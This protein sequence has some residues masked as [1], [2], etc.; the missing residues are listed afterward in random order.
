MSAA[1]ASVLC[2]CTNA[3][4]AFATQGVSTTNSWGFENPTAT[5]INMYQPL[6]LQTPAPSTSWSQVVSFVNGDTELGT[7]TLNVA[8]EE[9]NPQGVTSA[10]VVWRV[11]AGETASYPFIGDSCETQPS[12][13]QCF[14]TVKIPRGKEE[15]LR[16]Q[17]NFHAANGNYWW[18]AAITPAAGVQQNVGLIEV[19]DSTATISASANVVNHT[20]YI[21]TP[22]SCEETPQS[23]IEWLNPKSVAPGEE[24]WSE[25]IGTPSIAAGTCEAEFE[26]LTFGESPLTGIR[27]TAPKTHKRHPTL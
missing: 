25:P 23:S 4:S 13:S 11:A 18:D 6:I 15:I 19:P 7:S 5:I 26:E 1:A 24:S 9:V 14:T 12:Y 27:V 22:T 21:G 17:R 16:L 20:T 3:S 2:V 8:S 10:L